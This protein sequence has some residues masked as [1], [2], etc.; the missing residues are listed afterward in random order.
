MHTIDLLQEGRNVRPEYPDAYTDVTR[1]TDG[2]RI[3]ILSNE[4]DDIQGGEIRWSADE[5]SWWRVTVDQQEIVSGAVPGQFYEDLIT[6]RFNP[7][8]QLGLNFLPE[9]GNTQVFPPMGNLLAFYRV[10]DPLFGEIPDEG[11]LTVFEYSVEEL[12]PPLAADFNYDDSIDFADFLI[13]SEWYE[14]ER[15]DVDFAGFPLHHIGDANMDGITDVDDFMILS[16][17]FGT[18]RESVASTVVPEPSTAALVTFGLVGL[19]SL[20]RRR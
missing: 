13:L 2:F 12:R 19:G 14:T 18:T 8:R 4:L 11:V 6:L 16:E 5:E 3:E 10:T 9:P 17:S 20:R 15:N 1:T 7:W